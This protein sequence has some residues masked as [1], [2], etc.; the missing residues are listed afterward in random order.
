MTYRADLP[1][2]TLL[3]KT[4][5]RIEILKECIEFDCSDGTK[6]KLFHDSDCCESVDIEDINGEIDNLLNTPI[7]LAKESTSH[8]TPNDIKRD[9]VP[10][11]QTWTFYRLGTIKGYVDIRWFGESNGYY[12]ESVS[13]KERT[14]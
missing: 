6:Y 1:F 8:D 7:L 2:S 14:K 3:G 11:S 9:Y 4:C 10:E 12:S 5:T 13:F